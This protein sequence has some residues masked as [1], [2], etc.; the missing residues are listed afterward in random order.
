MVRLA[1]MI[2]RPAIDG[3][4]MHELPRQKPGSSRRLPAAVIGV[5]FAG[6]GVAC[7]VSILSADPSGT[8][9]RPAQS[10]QATSEAPALA[11]VFK[12][13]QDQLAIK[14]D[15]RFLYVG[16]S[17]IPDHPMMI[18]ITAWQQQVPLPQSYVGDNA[19][20]IPLHP[21]KAGVPLS[22]KTHF[23]RGAI[24][25]AANG[26]PI[27]NP[28]KNDGHT[29]TFL[30]G[31]LD[32]HGGH[33]GRADDYHY[34]IAPLF[35][36]KAVGPG[37]P[38]AVALDGYPIYGS[39]EP[40]GTPLDLKTLDQFNGHVD[41]KGN[42][43]YHGT[44][45]YPYVNGGFHGEV[46]DRGG[47]VDPQP[48]ADP[49]RD[50]GAPLRGAK[51]TAFT[52]TQPQ[53]YTLTYEAD[54]EVRKIN[55]WIDDAGVYHFEYVDGQGNKTVKIYHHHSHDGPADH[56]HDPQGNDTPPPPR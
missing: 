15:E 45:A 42:Y 50:A 41:A 23:F 4:M 52:S 17:G 37:H 26:V 47:Q 11:A 30:A 27:F 44:K 21:V 49:V 40:D 7:L 6:A 12:P 33:S 36:E 22:A 3:S 1:M 35:L 19:W 39:T 32:D 56:H 34:H 25:I 5:V 28:I 53:H 54:E 14:W 29:D 13:F 8:T 55:Y 48:H 38:I 10:Q 51:I 2:A 24:A 9:G 31:E 20:R 46:T 16:S 43:H 18:G